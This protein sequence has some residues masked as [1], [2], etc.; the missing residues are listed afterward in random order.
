[1]WGAVRGA[2]QELRAF[3]A[4]RLP[5][6]MVPSAW[7]LLDA[8]PLTPNG[9]LDRKA[10][11]AP[12]WN[13]T[14]QRDSFAAPRTP[15]EERLAAI[16]AEVLGIELVGVEDNFFEIG[17]HSLLATRV[18]ARARDVF[19]VDLPLQKLFE[20][21]TVAG[22]A[23]TIEASQTTADDRIVAL[24]RDDENVVFPASFAQRRLWLLAQLDPG[25]AAYHVPLSIRL[26][27]AL[28]AAALTASFNT[29]I[30]RHEALRT[31]FVLRAG[32]PVQHV[33]PPAALPLP[34]HDLRSLPEPQRRAQLA[35][36]QHHVT[37]QPFDLTRAPLLRAALL[38]L[39]DTEHLLLLC[40]HHIVVD[41]WS[42][43]VLVRELAACYRALRQEQP[44]D[45]PDLPIQYADFALW[46]RAWLQGA[47][48]DRLLAY[49]KAQLANLTPLAL[50]TDR[51]RPAMLSTAGAQQPISFAP[52][53]VAR[54]EH[55]SQQAG[56]TLFM[57][58]LAT[59]QVLLHR[60]SG[61]EDI[62]VGTPI[63]NR[64]RAESEGIVGCF[65]NTLVLRADLSG[66]PTFRDLLGRV[67][68]ICL[69]AYGHQDLPFELAVDLVQP[70]RDLSHS[71][72]FQVLFVLQNT[73]L[74]ALDLPELHTELLP[75]DTGSAKFE[76]TLDLSPGSDG[77][78]F[79]YLEYATDLF[80]A[81][82]IERMA[83]HLTTLLESVAASPEQTIGDLPLLPSAERRQIL[84]EWNA[85]GSAYPVDQS[86]AT[87]FEAQAARTPDAVAVVGGDRRLT[88]AE[89]DARANQLAHHLRMLGVT[90]EVCVGVCLQ[91]SPEL[92]VGLLG[93]LKA[94]GAYVPLDPAYPRERLQ[95]MLLDSGARVLLAQQA[96]L[97]SRFVA[98]HDRE[99]GT[100]GA[101]VVLIDRDWTAITRQP[102]T[103]PGTRLDP[104][105]LAYIIYTSGSTGRPKG[106]AITHRNAVA[107]IHWAG[108]V[109][110][111]DELAGTLAATAL[112]F[113]L[114]V[115]ELFVPLSLGGTVILAENALQ[116]PAAGLPVT[117]VNTVPS[118]I[119]ELL[120]LDMLPDSVSTVNLAGEP[121]PLDLVR[122]L[123]ARSHIRRVYNLYGPSEDTTYSTFALQERL[124]DDAPTIG[125]PISNS[126]A[127][128]LDARLQPV[129]IGVIG[130][131]Y[132]GG[133][134]L[135]RGYLGRPDLTAER[136]LPDPFSGVAGSRL[137][138]TGDLVRYLPNGD[139]DYIGRIDHQIKLRG[140]RIELGEIEAALRQH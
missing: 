21:P 61:Q 104:A 88:Y 43:G 66:N 101:A 64:T 69:G 47:T 124:S 80:A 13:G 140:Y 83:R 118:A 105:N 92:V 17:G 86:I 125:R 57:T 117:L 2:S 11:P 82:T 97:D 33:Q 136:F 79:G 72:L 25:S 42:L 119:T 6:Y 75:I 138:R 106:V 111:P 67:R 113:D 99:A 94:G 127:Y 27:G 7:V 48:L 107:L 71:P 9:K 18:I 68:E 95:H 100:E 29:L 53:L 24:P 114:S 3:L 60:Y 52:A 110:S 139:L 46:Q 89:L 39:G 16:W 45:L 49:W 131:L 132:L 96:L 102:M 8:L 58:L 65:A 62:A 84:D 50:P 59:L 103:A 40:L 51:P 112:S 133:V 129:A 63:A 98:D 37:A 73:S 78:L 70:E 36:L 134:G 123:Y 120:R 121:L 41:G 23:S 28:D 30:A 22:L 5:D 93:I 38:R 19:Q 126:R 130:E 12:E 4:A 128:V 91:R 85:T 56:T 122:Q 26:T 77:G 20:A 31:S 135:A 90:P 34:C 74:P 115:F 32:Q 35:A 109:F 137:Y 44:P 81:D 14:E 1:S 87:L 116:W 55:L 10:L 108:T 76:L 54:L 15:T